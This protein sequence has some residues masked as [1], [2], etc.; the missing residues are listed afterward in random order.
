MSG[1]R[2]VL[3]DVHLAKAL[4]EMTMGSRIRAQSLRQELN[5]DTQAERWQQIQLAIAGTAGG[6]AAWSDQI[7]VDFDIYFACSP[8]NRDSQLIYPQ[9]HYGSVIDTGDPVVIH[10]L[11]VSWIRDGNFTVQG[12]MIRWGAWAPDVPSDP[13]TFTGALHLTFQGYGAPPD[14]SGSDLEDDLGSLSGAPPPA[15]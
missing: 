8:A 5:Y 9:F 7:E 15:S 11:V 10:A 4:T 12:A 14:V 3:A 6:T 1:T 2:A 13:Y